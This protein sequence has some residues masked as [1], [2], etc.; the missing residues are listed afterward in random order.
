MPFAGHTICCAH[1]F[2]S[3]FA[4]KPRSQVASFLSERI[5]GLIFSCVVLGTLLNL[6]PSKYV[7]TLNVIWK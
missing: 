3:L 6:Y 7:S 5:L 1:A 4:L 2:S